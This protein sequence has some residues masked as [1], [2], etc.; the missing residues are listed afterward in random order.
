MSKDEINTMTEMTDNWESGTISQIWVNSSNFRYI[1]EDVVGICDVELDV[2][3]YSNCDICVLR[4]PESTSD[5]NFGDQCS[6]AEVT[7]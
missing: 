7:R 6:D 3:N 4:Q 1:D 2:Q 5:G